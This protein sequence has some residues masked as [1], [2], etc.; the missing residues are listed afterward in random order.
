[1]TLTDFTRHWGTPWQWKGCNNVKK[2]VPMNALSAVG[3]LMTLIDFT[4][5]WGTPWQ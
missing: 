4:C 1:M 5:Q 2:Y 3:A